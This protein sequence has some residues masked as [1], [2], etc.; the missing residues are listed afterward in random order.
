LKDAQLPNGAYPAIAPNPLDWPFS[1]GGPAWADA[2]VIIPW[3]IYQRY[4]D[5]SI[6]EQCYE[7]MCR[8]IKFLKET[9]RDGLRCYSDYEGWHG[10]GDWLALDGSDG[11]EGGTSK[12]L[13]GT[14]FYAHSTHL[15]SRI[16][17]L[18]DKPQD[19]ADF[20]E[21]SHTAKR[22]F[23]D[24]FVCEDG[25]I[26]EGTQTAYVLA[27]HFSLMPEELQFTA[28]QELVRMIKDNDD[29]LSTGFVGTPYINWVLSEAGYLST[30]YNL[31]LQTTWP[32]W[33]YSVL[34]GGTTI[35]ERWDGWTHDNGF[36]DQNMNS[37]NHYAYG[38]IGAWLYAFVAGIDLDP[39]Q[40]GYKHVM[41]YPR[42]GGG[43]T[44]AKAHFHSMYG[45]IRSAWK[46]ENGVFEWS[47]SVPANTSA[48]IFL[49]A[50][51]NDEVL[52]GAKPVED[53]DTVSLVRH[54]RNASVYEIGS[55]DYRFTVRR[56]T[57]S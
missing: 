36:Q 15:M 50:G 35:W 43:L 29:H 37:F 2:G 38:A 5:T 18:L 31:L 1:E 17:D 16:A 49:P 13:I 46:L 23:Q 22:A 39:L 33:L 26:V 11:R 9:S 40:P 55:G 14:A 6:L 47:V 44:N 4:G 48:T 24:K 3:E 32:S 42:P 53:V 28:A 8:Y 25:T 7:S 20:R 54:D 34:N 41:M 27:L 45:T 12:E 57:E 56:Q 21:L 10:F 52:E 51:K 19:A 30:A